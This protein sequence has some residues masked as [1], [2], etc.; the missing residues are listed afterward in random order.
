VSWGLPL[1]AAAVIAERVPRPVSS[2]KPPLTSGYHDRVRPAVLVCPRADELRPMNEARS[3]TVVQLAPASP[4]ADAVFVVGMHASGAELL[5]DALALLGVPSVHGEDGLAAFN[6]RLLLAAT[7]AG[8]D[9]PAATPL[10]LVHD[11]TP[12][13]EDARRKADGLIRPGPWAWADPRL[14]FLVPFWSEVLGVRPAVILV[15][16]AP[17]E[18]AAL[19]LPGVVDGVGAAAAWDRY[20]RSALVLCARFPSLV[21]G[22]DQLR[23][24]AKETLPALASF[25]HSVGIDAGRDPAPALAMLDSALPAGEV[26][27]TENAEVEPG[28]LTLHRLLSRLDGRQLGEDAERLGSLVDVTADFYDAD[29]YGVSYDQGG[30]PY[31]REEEVWVDFFEGIA[32][33]ITSTLQP[34]SCLDA[35]CAIGI[36]VEALRARGVDARGFDLSPWAIKQI[37]AH[38]QPFCWVG[39]VTEEIEGHYDLITCIEV[40]EHLPPWLAEAAVA[41]LCRH[42]GAVLFSSTPDDFVEPTHLNVEPGGYWANLFLRHGFVRDLDYDASYLA[43]H[44]MLFRPGEADT[45]TLVVDYER[46]LWAAQRRARDAIEENGRQRDAAIAAARDEVDRLNES[47]VELQRRRNAENLASF[48]AIRYYEAGNRRLAGMVTVREGQLEDV[49]NTKVL[50]YTSKLRGLYARLRRGGPVAVAASLA[51]AVVPE[52]LPDGSYQRWVEVFDTIDDEDRRQ[53][54]AQLRSLTRRPTI[55]VVM[56]TYNPPVAMLRAAIE[57][58]RSQIYPDWELCIA[59]DCSTDPDVPRLLEEYARSDPRVKVIGRAKNGHISAASNTALTLV[60]G[61]WVALLDHDDILREHALAL[62]AMALDANPDAGIVYSDEDKLDEV[63]DRRDPFFKPSFDPLLLLGQ[64]FVSHL[65]VFRK[66]LIDRVGGYRE[67][68]EGSQDWDLTLRVSELLDP[69][70]VVHIPHV[71]YHWRAHASSTASLVSA[72]P[73]AVEAGERVVVDHLERTGR[74]AKT[75][76]IGQSGFNRV[77]WAVPDP[78]PRVS[79]IVPTRDGR[80]LP[81]CI[82]SVLAFTTYPNF[83]VVVVDNSSRTDATLKYLRDNDHRITVIRDSR[84]FSHSKIN[85]DAVVRTSGEIVCLL[86]DDTEVITGEWLTEMVSQLYQPGIG[87]VGAKLYYGDGRIQHAGVLLGVHGVAGHAHRN[88][89]RLSAGYFGHLQLA[90]RMSAVTA[91]CAVVRREAWEEVHGFDEASLPNVLNDVDLCLRLREAGWDIVWTPYAELFHH[92]STSRGLDNEGPQGEAYAQAVD[93]VKT[94][95]GVAGLRN[96]PYYSPNL[97]L[98]DEDF[99]LAWPPRVPRSSPG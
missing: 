31:R 9:L 88:Y 44:A 16:R 78:A 91:A 73:Y 60:T 98:D 97:S 40:L 86:N 2:E 69:G 46:A 94:R 85:N 74:E 72:K 63:G 7:G 27:D 18:I 10:E 37:P 3:D 66:D 93:W 77:T 96:D 54:A 51:P 30:V 23:S 47:L 11:L 28:H 5:G 55:S 80:L 62:V 49:Y 87:M 64:N 39:S 53:I 92:E 82:D 95:W 75:T 34:A 24:R 68:Y 20:N 8:D 13:S 41:N 17:E 43:P 21:V 45:E 99:S 81:R 76:R 48:D 32:Q 89:D 58:V 70:Q 71:L 79:I 83:E 38:L 42:A 4:T 50:R 90:H 35:G 52:H 65:G 1:P 61:E 12:W 59:D 57:S 36:L 67:G 84:P 33:S 25:L 14:S 19:A 56:P 26:A 15:H 29:Y 6:D 22:H